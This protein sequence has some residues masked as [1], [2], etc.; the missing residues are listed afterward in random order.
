MITRLLVVIG[1]VLFKSI[2]AVHII[3]AIRQSLLLIGPHLVVLWCVV[4]FTW[5][6]Q[7]KAKAQLFTNQVGIQFL[8]LNLQ[9]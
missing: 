3:L 4:S 2:L 9:V 1:R 5:W 6:K 7:S 8:G